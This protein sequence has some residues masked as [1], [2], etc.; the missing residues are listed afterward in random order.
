MTLTFCY[1][2]SRVKPAL[3]W[4]NVVY[5]SLE[6][7][8]WTLESSITCASILPSPLSHVHELFSP[9]T[10]LTPLSFC[11]GWNITFFIKTFCKGNFPLKFDVL[12]WCYIFIPHAIYR[13]ENFI[14][15]CLKNTTTLLA[16]R[17]PLC[18]QYSWDCNEFLSFLPLYP[19]VQKHE[20]LCCVISAIYMKRIPMCHFCIWW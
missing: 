20:E 1:C 19:S 13:N 18:H 10:P 3:R 4:Q 9:R 15:A 12:W 7:N 14:S 2:D 8:T 5:V 16:L 17:Q 6:T 11:V